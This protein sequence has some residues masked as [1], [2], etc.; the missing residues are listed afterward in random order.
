MNRIINGLFVGFDR[1]GGRFVAM[2]GSLEDAY[3]AFC[4][5]YATVDPSVFESS[6]LDIAL[7][8]LSVENGMCVAD[9]V[10]VDNQP[11]CVIPF[12]MLPTSSF[13]QFV[14]Q[15]LPLDLLEEFYPSFVEAKGEPDHGISLD[16]VMEK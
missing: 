1:Y 8:I 4:S 6:F 15:V 16:D 13:V 2:T 14:S 11:K 10:P 7:Q 5:F 12:A 3:A 9:A